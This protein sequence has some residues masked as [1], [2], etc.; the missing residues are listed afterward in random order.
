MTSEENRK[1]TCAVE[2]EPDF[3]LYFAGWPGL[4]A[5]TSETLS[6]RV[7]RWDAFGE[8]LRQETQNA[9]ARTAGH[10]EAVVGLQMQTAANFFSAPDGGSFAD[11]GAHYAKS[12]L[13]LNARH[14][15]RQHRSTTT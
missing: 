8:T 14:V 7:Q 9:A 13:D 2:S 15:R 12:V 11:I 4:L 5:P 10:L 3:A 6:Q 1:T